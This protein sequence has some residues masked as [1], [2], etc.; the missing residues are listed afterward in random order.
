MQWVERLRMRKWFNVTTVVA[1]SAEV[2]KQK[3]IAT[4]H[5]ATQKR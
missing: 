2:N 3:L 1:D 5:D 4:L